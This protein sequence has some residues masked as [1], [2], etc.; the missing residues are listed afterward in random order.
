MCFCLVQA[1]FLFGLF[2]AD[3]LDRP[4]HRAVAAAPV[5]AR[6]A[7]RKSNKRHKQEVE[8]LLARPDAIKALNRDSARHLVLRCVLLVRVL[9]GRFSHGNFRS[10]PQDTV[11]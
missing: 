9:A 3:I 2:A 7:A 4:K 8:V 10:V 6:A 1:Y 5:V 11:F